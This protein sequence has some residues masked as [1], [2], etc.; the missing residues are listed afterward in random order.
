MDLSGR[1]ALVTGGAV[2]VGRA[3]TKALASLFE[4][5]GGTIAC[6]QPVVSLDDLP[7]AAAYVFDTTTGQQIRKI[8]PPEV[9]AGDWFGFDVGISGTTA[10]ISS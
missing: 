8:V 3:I 6:G 5:L 2:R 4:S 7:Q 10:V 1:N 9:E